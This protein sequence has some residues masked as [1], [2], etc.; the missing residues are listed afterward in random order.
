MGYGRLWGVSE[1]CSW[2]SEQI[3]TVA[4]QGDIEVGAIGDVWL[5]H[6]RGA[7]E[8]RDPA[9]FAVGFYGFGH[10]TL[11]FESSLLFIFFAFLRHRHMRAT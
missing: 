4:G 9:A 8:S 10:P 5:V 1:V 3:D 2:G 6:P 11:F 7:R